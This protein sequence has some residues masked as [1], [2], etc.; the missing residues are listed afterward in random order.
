MPVEHPVAV[1]VRSGG[2]VVARCTLAWSND[3]ERA[4]LVMA[5]AVVA[6][7]LG[8]DSVEARREG[9]EDDPGGTGGQVAV[10]T[11]HG[12]D[13]PA[14]LAR[15]LSPLRDLL[16]PNAG[17]RPLAAEVDAARRNLA[18]CAAP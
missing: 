15:L 11:G 5:V 16:P 9:D 14:P 13:G 4:V 10:V 12:I 3:V 17:F 6:L 1:S 18:A 8:A 2:E 7:D